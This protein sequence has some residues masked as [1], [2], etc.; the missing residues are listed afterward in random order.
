VLAALRID[1]NVSRLGLLEVAEHDDRKPRALA[2]G[3]RFQSPPV[4][5]RVDDADAFLRRQQMLDDV[6]QRRRFP[7]A[8]LAEHD[9]VL[10]EN[11]FGEDEF[12]R[13]DG[14]RHLLS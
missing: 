6:P 13:F 14:C 8:G 3:G 12:V 5:L 10:I 11:G 4:T 9:R 2:V 1:R 7:G